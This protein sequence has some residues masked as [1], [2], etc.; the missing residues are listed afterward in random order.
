MT[1]QVTNF[2]SSP[3]IPK[4]V[5]LGYTLY[6]REVY[7]NLPRY[8]ANEMAENLVYYSIADRGSHFASFEEPQLVEQELRAFF[9]AIEM[10]DKVHV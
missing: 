8:L 10:S 7:S 3:K 4:Q 6:P 9:K 5:K 1:K 2:F